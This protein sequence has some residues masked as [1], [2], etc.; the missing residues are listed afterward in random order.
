M[1]LS[2]MWI[3]RIYS[4]FDAWVSTTPAVP[5][6]PVA[7]T[8]PTA[9]VLVGC[10]AMHYSDLVSLL[11]QNEQQKAMV[12]ALRQR[13]GLNEQFA[14]LCLEEMAWNFDQALAAF[15]QAKVSQRICSMNMY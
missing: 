7:P 15:E 6:A 11:C 3:L 8:V 12:M 1:I 14:I 2:D 10:V 9:P 13:T 4:G 5:A